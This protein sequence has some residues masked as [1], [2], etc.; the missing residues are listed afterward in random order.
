M[1]CEMIGVPEEDRHLIFEWSN[2]LVGARR[3]R[4]SRHARGAA[5]HGGRPRSTRYC[6]AIAADRRANPR[7]DIM[8]AL[9]QAE[10][11]GDRLSQH[12]LN[13]FFVHAVRGRQRDHPQPDRPRHAR[14]DRAPRGRA[15]AGASIDDD[16][17]WR[18]PPRRSSAGAARSTTSAAPPRRDT[19][20]AGAADRGGRQG[21]HL[22]PV[23]QPRRGRVRRSRTRFD[24][25][26]TPNDHRHLRRRRHALLPRRQPGP[27][28]DQGHDRASSCAATPTSSWPASPAACAPTSSTASS[29][30]PVRFTPDTPLPS[31]QRRDPHAHRDL[32]RS[33]ASSSRS[34]PSPTAATSSPR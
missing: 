18:P 10:I 6:D 21:R 2:Q 33:S 5:R 11:D 34:S 17:L 8:T 14:P 7:D 24:I 26:R 29:A 23:R 12:E 28:R 16:A 3:T 32:R 31:R 15:A 9:V 27:G 19:E 22:L 25:R 13:M 1:I 30:M 4:T 20:I